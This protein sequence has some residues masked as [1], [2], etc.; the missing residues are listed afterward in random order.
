MI[1]FHRLYPQYCIEY[2]ARNRD[3]QEAL[4]DGEIE[5]AFLTN[6]SPR[7]SDHFQSIHFAD[8]E[9]LILLYEDHPLARQSSISMEQLQSEDFIM[10][11]NEVVNNEEFS[12]RLGYRTHR[13]RIIASVPSGND[14]IRM[15]REKIGI[16]MIHGRMDTI[17]SVPGLRVLPLD[18]PIKY[19]LNI[20]FRNDT[21]LS[22]PAEQF[23]NYAKR[24]TSTHKNIN[25][26]LIEQ[27][28]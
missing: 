24:W 9:M 8:E 11:V 25:Q 7:Y 12:S 5:I 27:S 4:N 23:V 13:P 6:L 14:L 20:Y 19:E 26:S 18:P 17:P 22:A 21:P 16:S 15:V 2:Y 1:D 28:L 3:V 10:L